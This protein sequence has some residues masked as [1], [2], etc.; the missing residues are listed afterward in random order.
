MNIRTKN[1]EA[2]AFV[3]RTKKNASDKSTGVT[4]GV[5]LLLVT[6]H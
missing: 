1:K 4:M 2:N 3:A 6:H 5:K